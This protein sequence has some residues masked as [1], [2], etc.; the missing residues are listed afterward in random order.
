MVDVTP[1]QA[2]Y[3]E[4]AGEPEVFACTQGFLVDVLGREVLRDAA[5]VRVGQLRRVD[6]VIEEV[7]YIYIVHITLDGLHIDI[8][9]LLLLR[10][11][12]RSSSRPAHLLIDPA[13]S[14]AT[15]D[16]RLVCVLGVII[17]ARGPHLFVL[18]L[19]L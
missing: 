10:M 1:V 12:C 7:V 5:V 17:A 14:D 19:V 3:H 11:R 8:L 18:I 9:R 15:S 4:R 13:A 2:L 6:L 16:S